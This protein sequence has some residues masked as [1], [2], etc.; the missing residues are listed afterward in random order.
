MMTQVGSMTANGEIGSRLARLP[1]VLV[2][3]V[4]LLLSLLHCTGCGL[5]FAGSDSAVVAMST[6]PGSA[7]DVP[8][9]LLPC[10]AGHCLSHVTA[11]LVTVVL[12]PVNHALRPPVSGREQF[13]ASVAGLPLFKPPRA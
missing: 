3:T 12:T 4:G 7:P 2:L 1:L 8:E 9:Q 13:P 5:S 6:D 10:H 11:Q